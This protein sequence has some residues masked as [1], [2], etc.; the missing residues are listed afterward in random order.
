M[1]GRHKRAERKNVSRGNR[2]DQNQRCHRLLHFK[3]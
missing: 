3:N 1:R 2:W